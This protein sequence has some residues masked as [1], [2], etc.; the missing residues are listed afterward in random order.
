[1]EV[2]IECLG[3][4]K[5]H[6]TEDKSKLSWCSDG[7][8]TNKG[9]T[10]LW[11]VTICTRYPKHILLLSTGITRTVPRIQWKHPC[12]RWRVLACTVSGFRAHSHGQIRRTDINADIW[13]RTASSSSASTGTSSSRNYRVCLPLN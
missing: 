11:P 1:M 5:S 4:P 10:H 9:N 13:L 2:S 6:T 7:E 8:P 3:V 12:Y